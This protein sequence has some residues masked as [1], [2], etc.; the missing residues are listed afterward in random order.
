MAPRRDNRLARGLLAIAAPV[1]VAA[2]R[3][4]ICHKVGSTPFRPYE[5]SDLLKKLQDPTLEESERHDLVKKLAMGQ[6]AKPSRGARMNASARDG[7]E[8]GR[9]ATARP[10]AEVGGTGDYEACSGELTFADKENFKTIVI[11]VFDDNET[12]DDEVF[13]VDL[14]E[15]AHGGKAYAPGPSATSACESRSST[16]ASP[17]S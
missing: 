3:D 8:G 11:K 1:L 9:R 7:P 4:S 6:K 15:V 12:E 14:L 10:R 2:A 5:F 13:Y 16:T 17:A